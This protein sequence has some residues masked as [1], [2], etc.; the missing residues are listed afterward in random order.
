MTFAVD[1][2]ALVAV[3]R[4]EDDAPQIV[5][6]LGRSPRHLIS[7]GSYL[8]ACLVTAR[9]GSEAVRLKALLDTAAIDVVSVSPEDAEIA[10]GAFLRYGRG[11]GH[12][13]QLNFGDCFAYALAK[14]RNLPLLFKGDDF[15]HTDIEPALKPA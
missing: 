13:A 6:A 11:S 15:I 7:A 8:E 12:P 1:T 3:L 4:A 14:A 5:Q 9:K 2:S 10:A